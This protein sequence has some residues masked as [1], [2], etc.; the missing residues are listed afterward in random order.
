M[1]DVGGSGWDG[2]A[3]DRV[4]GLQRWVADRTLATLVVDGD[5]RAL[6]VGCGDGRVTAELARLLPRGSVLGID[7]SPGMLEI[8]RGRLG[9]TVP[10]LAFAEGTA[11]TLDRRDAFDLVVSFNALHWVADHGVALGRMAHA[12]VPGGRA[13]LQLVCE[14]D[15]PS[16][17][18]VAS[19]VAA[20]TAYSS[21]VGTG[22]APYHHPVEAVFLDQVRAAG[23]E[24]VHSRVDDLSWDFGSPQVLR[25]WLRVGFSAWLLRLP[26]TGVREAFVDD[27]AT[28]YADVLG[29]TTVV[30]FLQLCVELRRP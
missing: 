23:L 29:A 27:V 10:N 21:F 25:E 26:D 19:E 11:E 4:N 7:P 20:R 15:R 3:Y 22:I 5:E 16:V 8:A 17:E 12:L 28:S 9:P 2:A 13:V 30:R 1:T 14:G 24:V 6:D 18:D